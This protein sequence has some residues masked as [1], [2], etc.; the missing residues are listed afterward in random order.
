MRLFDS[1]IEVASFIS[2]LNVQSK[3]TALFKTPPIQ[4]MHYPPHLPATLNKL[5]MVGPKIDHGTTY[6]NSYSKYTKNAKLALHR[7][8]P[9]RI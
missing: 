6:A 1:R 3:L 4:V 2:Y 5:K 9:G 8:V 7:S